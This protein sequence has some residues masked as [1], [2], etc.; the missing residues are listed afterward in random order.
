MPGIGHTDNF[1]GTGVVIDGEADH[2]FFGGGD[3]AEAGNHIV[4][5]RADMGNLAQIVDSLPEFPDDFQCR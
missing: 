3:G 1:D 4:P 5:D 2:G